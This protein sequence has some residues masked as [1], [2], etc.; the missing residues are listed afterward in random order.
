MF[1]VMTAS[2]VLLLSA[3]SRAQQAPVDSDRHPLD[4]LTPDEYSTVVAALSDEAFLGPTGLYPLI[5]LQEPPKEDVLNWRRGDPVRRQ[6]F[7]I[8]KTRQRTF[9]AVVDVSNGSVLS[10]EEMEGVEPS[11][12]LS[13][14]WWFAHRKTLGDERVRAALAERG[15]TQLQ[16]VVCLPHTVGYYGTPEEEERRLVKVICYDSSGVENFWGRPIEGLIT[17]LDLRRG[18]VTD[19]IDTGAVP[20]PRSLVD[21]DVGSADLPRVP[22]RPIEQIRPDNPSAKVEGQVVTWQNW[23]FHFR[24]DPRVGVIVSTVRFRGDGRWRSVLYAGSLSELFVPYMDPDVGWYFRTYLD[25]GEYGLGK[26][27][28]EL[29]QE[30]DCPRNVQFFSAILADDWGDPYEKERVACLFERYAGDVAWR[31]YDAAAERSKVQRSTE[32]VLRSVSAVGNYDYTFDWIFRQDGSVK[33]AVG[34]SGIPQIKAIRRLIATGDPTGDELAHG[35]MVAKH[36]LA[37]HHDHFFSFRLDLDVDGR[38]NTFVVERLRTAATDGASPRKSIWMLEAEAAATEQTAKLRIDLEAPALWRVVNPSVVGPLGYPVSY[39]LK[40]GA[41]AVSLLRPDDW[42]QRRA[43]FTDYHLWVTPYEPVE[44]Y[45]AGTYPNQSRGHEG[46]PRWT[47]SDRPIEDTDI[48]LWYT[49]GFHHVVRAEDWPVQPT[50]WSG[51]ELRPFDFFERNPTLDLP[52]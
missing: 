14:E 16:D 42:P 37:V 45:A 27:A 38:E 12:L 19:V 40:P 6:A 31:H 47:A 48:V 5:T 39:E 25:A 41:N 23:Q 11:I 9:E 22:P 18:E 43:G 32:L 3:G 35:H 51:F 15:I 2:L 8:A 28:V 44:R 1:Q 34:T 21:F 24:L 33:V 7:V 13:E 50:S 46:L 36:S 52:R 30:L 10:W 29:E 26:L 4:P 17:V 20:I 49:L